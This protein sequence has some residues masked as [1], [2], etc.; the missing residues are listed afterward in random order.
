[1]VTMLMLAIGPVLPHLA[2]GQ[3]IPAKQ[4]QED[5]QIMRHSLEEAH[6]G[7]YRYTS[8]AEMDRTFDRAYRQIDHPMTDMEFWRLAG[9]VVAHIKCGH[10]YLWFPKAVVT[11][12]NTTEP[13]FTAG[14]NVLHNRAFIDEAYGESSLALAGD[15]IL[16]INGVPTRKILKELRGMVT[17][18]GNSRTA[19]DWRIG[20]AGGFGVRLYTLGIKSP[21]LV[22]CRDRNGKRELVRMAGMTLPDYLKARLA[23]HPESNT[24]VDLRFLDGGHIAVLTI[25]HWYLYADEDHKQT[26]SDFLNTVFAQIREKGTRNLIIDV[27]GNAG[28]WDIPVVQLFGYLWDQPFHDYQDIVCNAREFD[29]FRYAPDARPMPGELRK[30]SDGKLHVVKQTGLGPQPP[31]EPHYAGRV[32]AL[33]DGGSFSSSTEFL[34]L[35]HFYKRGKFIGEEPAGAYYGYTCGHMVDLI[36]PN[37][38]LQLQFG[39]LTFYMDAS[40]YK[41]RDRGV[42]PDY[43]IAH[44]LADL[45]AGRDRDMEL[46]LSLA[47]SP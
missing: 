19:K 30:G 34:T 39:I 32:F 6:G 15:E 37:S 3:K 47:R 22:D 33:M 38:K 36:L 24:N 12:F 28:G 44:T 4:L 43:P 42:M 18:D 26:F 9:P 23:Q 13:I 35:L 27:R 16:S 40:G 29:F 14:A 45:L 8:K 31:L 5:F 1:M 10:T 2:L 7:I 21:F 17:G 20:H 41:Y 11:Q 46:A 25:R